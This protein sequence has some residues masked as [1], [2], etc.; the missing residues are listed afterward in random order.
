MIDMESLDF[1][2]LL[3]DPDMGD[4]RF[5]GPCAASCGFQ[6]SS[7]AQQQLQVNTIRTVGHCADHTNQCLHCQASRIII[8]MAF[9]PYGGQ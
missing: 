5:C 1:D 3:K 7:A 8:A 2:Q 6:N 9:N 4:A